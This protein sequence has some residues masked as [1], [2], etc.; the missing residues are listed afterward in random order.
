MKGTKFF[1]AVAPI[2]LPVA[3]DPVKEMRRTRGSCDQSGTGL[4]AEALDEV[5]DARG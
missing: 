4:V 1:A 3:G 5:E 2:D